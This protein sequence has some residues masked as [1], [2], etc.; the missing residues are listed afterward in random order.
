MWFDTLQELVRHLSGHHN[1]MLLSKNLTLRDW[2]DEYDNGKFIDSMMRES[3]PSHP[4]RSGPI[5]FNING[6]SADGAEK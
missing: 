1:N 5:Q 3:T 2:L 6:S 4:P